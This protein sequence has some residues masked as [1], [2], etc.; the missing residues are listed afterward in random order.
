MTVASPS[1]ALTRRHWFAL[2]LCHGPAR[3]RRAYRNALIDLATL[4]EIHEIYA[5]INT[6][7]DQRR[8]AETCEWA[9]G[10]PAP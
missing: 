2:V 5:A 8:W 4:N 9:R 6:T 7:N 3:V 1:F 10:A